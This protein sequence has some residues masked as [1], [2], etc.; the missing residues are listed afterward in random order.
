M[1]VEDINLFDEQEAEL[2]IRNQEIIEFSAKTVVLASASISR[3]E[4]M[5]SSGIKYVVIKNTLDE[6]KVKC[7]IT[8]I[9]SIEEY[10]KRLAYEKAMTLNPFLKNAVIISADT[11]A[12]C[13]GEIIG[14]PKD[15]ED[16]YRILNKLSGSVHSVIT[17]VC[18][19]D[20]EDVKNF[21][22]ISKIKMKEFPRQKIEEL[23]KDEKTYLYAG[24]YCIDDNIEGYAIFDDKDFN[25]IK[26]LPIEEIE[27]YCI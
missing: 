19:I 16:A 27:K 13:D 12:Y 20:G 22:V 4:I 14:K 5:E 10:V 25:N 1:F 2:A 24:G 23:V 9:E 15:E 17:G 21:T 18:I 8:T 3:R 26:G 6:E 7:D 11:V